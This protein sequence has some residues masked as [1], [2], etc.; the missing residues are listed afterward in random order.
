MPSILELLVLI[1]SYSFFFRYA[2]AG[3]DR[4]AVAALSIRGTAPQMKHVSILYSAYNGVN[5]TEATDVASL[6]N[7]SIKYNRGT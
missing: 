1:C 6:I 3:S 2:G 4:K 5:M 7:S